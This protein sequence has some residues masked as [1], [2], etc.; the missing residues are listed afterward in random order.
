MLQ[1]ASAELRIERRKF[2]DLIRLVHY[3]PDDGVTSG[4]ADLF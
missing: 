1:V 2:W 3:L 4:R